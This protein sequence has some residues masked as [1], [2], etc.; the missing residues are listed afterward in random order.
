M[1]KESGESKKTAEDMIQ[2]SIVASER[3]LYLGVKSSDTITICMPDCYE[4]SV[5]ALAANRIGAAVALL[6][7][8]L[9]ADEVRRHLE[10]VHSPLLI[11]YE[12]SAADNEEL[13]RKTDTKY[14]LTLKPR[15]TI[16]QL[17][18]KEI[19]YGN[20]F[21]PAAFLQNPVK[22]CTVQEIKRQFF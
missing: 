13:I 21:M 15:N 20:L 10:Q 3:F 16:A 14:V 11:N 17:Q 19:S 1:V 22:E 9:P 2:D 12:K 4:A 8:L 7:N 18:E 5:C 6:D